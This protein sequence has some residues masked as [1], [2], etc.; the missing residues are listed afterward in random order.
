MY[1]VM[2]IDDDVPVIKYLMELVDW[3]KLGFEVCATTFS[4]VKATHLF[5]DTN[6]DLVI[7][8]IGIPQMN[9]IQ[10]AKKFKQ[11]RPTVGIIFLTCHED[12][13]YAK[14]AVQINAEEY[15]I[16][17][18]L[19]AEILTEVLTRYTK[20]LNIIKEYTES[21]SV[22]KTVQRNMM[23]LKQSFI[24]RM[25][26]VHSASSL[27]EYAAELNMEWS[28]SH[29]LCAL[30]V[31]DN[32]AFCNRYSFKDATLLETGVLNIAEELCLENHEFTAMMDKD[33][34]FVIVYNFNKKLDINQN[35]VFHTF[36][37]E[38]RIKVQQL[39]SLTLTY[40]LTK[41]MNE[42]ASLGNVYTQLKQKLYN[43]FYLPVHHFHF[44]S[45]EEE[46]SWNLTGAD[47]LQ[48]LEENWMAAYK[49]GDLTKIFEFLNNIKANSLKWNIDPYV[50]KSTLLK[51]IRMVCPSNLY[52]PE[53]EKCFLK[54][55]KY[56]QLFD[57]MEHLIKSTL[58]KDSSKETS[59]TNKKPI[60]KEIDQY[61]M[62]HLSENTTSITMAN[63]LH[64][65]P[66]YF[67]RY[68]K[69]LSSENFTDYIHRLKMRIAA[70]ILL[71]SEETIEYIGHSLG[72]SDRTYFSKVFKKYYGFSPNDY[73]H[74]Q[75]KNGV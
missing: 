68:F 26:K 18:E 47:L 37:D 3:N 73:K 60:L 28:R 75:Q 64:L 42:L 12:F 21:A 45:P 36:L 8:D 35:H 27:R 39:L 11:E 50:L 20:K 46:I 22:R 69:R 71:E 9:G 17:D 56:A 49:Q 16:K 74:Q 65:N 51:W 40:H 54:V 10:L 44:I 55:D 62:E 29:F 25:T 52:S 70:K 19:T 7:T 63:Y 13:Q 30:G 6:P 59:N 24:E 32:T 15:L 38:L 5:K 31:I 1:K 57:M 14:Q 61:I 4:S 67:S 66:S 34:H 33:S 48:S 41:D 2:I 43:G 53:L 23:L 58:A 72:Y